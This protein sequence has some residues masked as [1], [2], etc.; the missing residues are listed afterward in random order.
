GSTFR[1]VIQVAG[2][3]VTS[4]AG[5]TVR[6]PESLV[7]FWPLPEVGSADPIALGVFRSEI[8]ARASGQ[9]LGPYVGREVDEQL[10]AALRERPFV[11]LK[12]DSKSG[13]SRTAFEVLGRTLPD[14]LLVVPRDP[15]AVRE[16]LA[17]D[18]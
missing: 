11:L 2:D 5:S 16:L 6:D 17:P 7:R 12:G 1:D 4:P 10:A 9:A 18:A 8:A 13:K 14:A 3:Y 15:Q